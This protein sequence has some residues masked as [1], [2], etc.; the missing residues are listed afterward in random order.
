MVTPLNYATRGFAPLPSPFHFFR[1]GEITGGAIAY[2]T[3][4]TL[5]AAKHNA[6]LLFTGLSPSAHA[7][8]SPED[9]SPGWW[10][11]LIGPGAA[12]DTRR[13]LVICLNSL[14]SCFGS[15]GPASINPATGLRYGKDFPALAIEDIAAGASAVLDHLGVHC[16]ALIAGPSLG[17]SAAL[18][19]AAL[20]PGRAQRL[21]TISGT[22]A[23]S[24]HAI[25]LRSI[26]RDAVKHDPIM[27]LRLARKLGT[28]TYRSAQELA[29]RFGRQPSSGNN[30]F[31]VQDYLEKQ[32]ERFA[33]FFDPQSFL[34][35]SRAIDLFD[36][37]RHGDPVA[38]F[39]RA[40]LEQALVIGVEEDLLFTIGEQAEIA[41][42]LE[43]AGVTTRF[44]RISSLTGHDAF[45]V[46]QER[47]SAVI[48]DWLNGS[49]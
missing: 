23:A 8:S 29:V 31:A 22:M 21:L 39:T 26:Q 20:Y 10:E 33:V 2:E 12:F 43:S 44:E 19:F 3:W 32:A 16:A 27:G 35:L 34:R 17:G 46:A 13:F 15:T 5:G 45:L 6:V 24:T 41:A 11:Q 25:A 42:A 1:G 7:A 47:F 4:G 36:L 14:G 18:A 37:R 9:P 28:A 40:K 49:A 48:R 30:D 38:V